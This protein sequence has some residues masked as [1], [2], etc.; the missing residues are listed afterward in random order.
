MLVQS[1]P[2][3]VVSVSV[4]VPPPSLLNPDHTVL[5]SSALVPTAVV[6]VPTVPPAGVATSRG[7]LMNTR[8]ADCLPTTPRE[9][10]EPKETLPVRGDYVVPEG[11]GN[12]DEAGIG[13]DTFLNCGD[14]KGA[15]RKIV[16]A[17]AWQERAM[18]IEFDVEGEMP[19]DHAIVELCTA[20]AMGY[21]SSRLRLE[22]AT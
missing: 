9:R 10:Q 8:A 15:S 20:V 7:I 18:N 5:P 1:F 16:H 13:G 11:A 17:A 6:P 22:K 2:C 21:A 4:P 14:L 19:S 12:D 3:A